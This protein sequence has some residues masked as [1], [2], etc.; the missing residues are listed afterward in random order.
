MSPLTPEAAWLRELLEECG[1]N[2]MTLRSN[3]SEMVTTE[4][5]A[6]DLVTELD[7]AIGEQLC[8]A[9]SRSFPGDRIVCEDI[10]EEDPSDSDA[11]R[12]RVWYVDPVDGT[13]NILKGLPFYALSVCCFDSVARTPVLSGIYAPALTFMVLAEGENGTWMDNQ[14][15]CVAPVNELR[16]ALVLFGLSKNVAQ[17]S[18]EIRASSYLASVSLGT[19]RSG[20]AALDLAFI[21]SGKA[22][23]YFHYSLGP[24]DISAGMHLVRNAGGR[25]TNVGS[26][27]L[28]LDEGSVIATNRQLHSELNR[29]LSRFRDEGSI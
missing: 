27:S 28:D 14:H 11:R 24:W 22:D 26:D 10:S 8:A 4:K 18:H 19:R 12:T 15:C 23:A 17:N 13:T 5:G 29:L 6:K 21:A 9:I 3:R 16:K 1:R 25:I 7:L 2:L 20:S